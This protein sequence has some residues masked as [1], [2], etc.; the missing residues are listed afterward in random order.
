M[1]LCFYTQQRYYS[2]N[3]CQFKMPFKDFHYSRDVS[4]EHLVWPKALLNK[5]L[6]KKNVWKDIFVWFKIILKGWFT[7]KMKIL[8]NFDI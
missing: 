3:R 2:A 5:L 8:R 4:T 7:Q 1:H 6:N